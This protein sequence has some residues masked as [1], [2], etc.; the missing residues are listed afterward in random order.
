MNR[1]LRIGSGGRLGG[2]G[3]FGLRGGGATVQ[4]IPWYLAGGVAAAN[5]KGAYVAVG[6]ANLAASYT[7]L[8]NPGTNDLTTAAAPTWD[9]AQGWIF[10]GGTPYLDT[11]IVPIDNQSW[12]QVV[13]FQGLTT[14]ALKMI[15]GSAVN[16]GA[17][18]FGPEPNTGSGA[19]YFY[20]DG[21]VNATQTPDMTN[22]NIIIAGRN[23]Y[24]NGASD[25]TIPA[26]TPNNVY[27]SA[28]IGAGHAP[29][30]I[31]IPPDA[32]KVQC[33]AIYDTILTAPQVA[34][35]YAAIQSA[36]FF[37]AP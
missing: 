25:A 24:R 34:A 20:G 23:C 28:Y 1:G 3:A 17:S 13:Q 7:N 32:V 30:G 26:S 10:S 12:T 29:N 11:G 27:A 22:G 21:G 35:I 2:L 18:V 33:Y 6:A 4:A 37:L 36:G 15:C 14:S 16:F 8:A 19:R 31:F 9:V 5:C